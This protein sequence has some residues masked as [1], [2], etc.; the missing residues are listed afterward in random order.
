MTADPKTL[1]VYSQRIADYQE[2]TT[3]TQDYR[4]LGDFINSLPAGGSV[5]DIGAGP[6]QDA[7]V[8]KDAG[9]SVVALE[10][11]PE[12]ADLI[13]QHGIEVQRKTFAQIDEVAQYDGAWA[14]FSLLHAKRVDLPSCLQKIATALKPGGLFVIGMKVGSGETRD[15][16]GRFY[17]YYSTDELKELLSAAGFIVKRCTEGAARG[18]AGSKDP[19]V[20]IDSVL[21]KKT[22][23]N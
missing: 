5:Y 8:M 23:K 17:S 9:L 6:G 21:A 18:L 11:T 12:F 2:M 10:P 7:K 13:E 4:N 22:A 15:K 1:A 16:L 19:Y 14:S 20:V 3:G